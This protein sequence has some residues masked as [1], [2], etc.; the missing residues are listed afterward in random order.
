MG[1]DFDGEY[2]ELVHSHEFD[3]KIAEL[4]DYKQ[5]EE[6]LAIAYWVIARDPESEDSKTGIKDI[7]MVKTHGEHGEMR[8]W[9]RVSDR[10]KRQVEL[11]FLEPIGF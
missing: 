3:A 2:W 9:Y 10:D 7:R 11:M 4:G 5:L 1:I 8:I 6:Q